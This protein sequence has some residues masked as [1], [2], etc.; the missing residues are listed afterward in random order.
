MVMHVGN[1]EGSR[2]WQGLLGRRPDWESAHPGQRVSARR[3]PNE[4]P[5]SSFSQYPRISHR[6]PVYIL[7]AEMRS[8]ISLGGDYAYLGCRRLWSRAVSHIYHLLRPAIDTWVR[9]GS[10]IA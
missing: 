9:R 7:P 2:A 8:K 6:S 4:D 5:N 1:S 10:R 3:S